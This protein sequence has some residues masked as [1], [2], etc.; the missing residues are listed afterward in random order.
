MCTVA[1]VDDQPV[2]RSGMERLIQQDP[3]LVVAA[4]VGHVKELATLAVPPD[5]VLVDLPLRTQ[6]PRTALIAR[7]A[8]MS[9]PIVISAWDKP[10]SLQA[11][12]RAGAYACLS[13]QTGQASVAIALR[14]VVGGRFY[15]CNQLREQLHAELTGHPRDDLT[16]L[17]PYEVET[18]RWIARGFTEPQIATRMGLSRATVSTYAKRIRAKFNA[19]NK[20]ELTRLAIQVGHLT[21]ER[22]A[23]PAA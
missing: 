21:D 23:H 9:R 20:A 10:P 4:W 17:A 3:T 2:R 7:S 22:T 16:G 15:G 1:I 6:G 13:G 8:D 14:V 12:I 19:T 5:L 18:L 11:A